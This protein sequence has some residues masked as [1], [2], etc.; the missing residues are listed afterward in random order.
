[1]WKGHARFVVRC[2]DHLD[3]DRV[4]ARS[5]NR[6]LSRLRRSVVMSINHLVKPSSMFDE[7]KG[8]DDDGDHLGGGIS[9]YAQLWT[10]NDYGL[11]STII[12]RACDLIKHYSC[13]LIAL[14]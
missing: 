7:I 1:M 3:V 8:G 14:Y 12:R 9:F 6:P 11:K 10:G 13:N 5:L 4:I 2:V